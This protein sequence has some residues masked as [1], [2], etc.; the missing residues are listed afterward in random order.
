MVNIRNL[1]VC[2]TESGRVSSGL[3]GKAW[4]LKPGEETI[5][6]VP[7]L[8]ILQQFI[9][10]QLLNVGTDHFMLYSY[11][12]ITLQLLKYVTTETKVSITSGVDVG[13]TLLGTQIHD[14]WVHLTFPFEVTSK[15]VCTRHIQ[16][17]IENCGAK[18]PIRTNFG[19]HLT[20][21]CC[22]VCSYHERQGCHVQAW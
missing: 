14:T 1:A 10:P 21:P 3:R 18:W 15:T 13:D 2:E 16:Q 11:S 9:L 19:Q 4:K 22:P 20:K 6:W 7:Y 5:R 8:D 17:T 12:S